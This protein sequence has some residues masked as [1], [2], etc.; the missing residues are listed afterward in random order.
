M[1][2]VLIVEDD[3]IAAMDFALEL[4][5]DKMQ[6]I[7]II[8]NGEEAVEFVKENK[9]DLIIMDI[10]LKGKISGYEAAELINIDNS[11]P[12]FFITGYNDIEEK[13][14][15]RIFTKPV[16]IHTVV[17]KFQKEESS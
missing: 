3:R 17:S 6:V 9:P 2:K 1:N 11:I 4:E 16:N 13:Y 8:D 5:R 7:K 12:I 10:H 15:N 14:K